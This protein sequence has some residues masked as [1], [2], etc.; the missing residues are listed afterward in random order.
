LQKFALLNPEILLLAVLAF[1]L[2]LGK[3]VGLRL[4]ELWRFR[5]LVNS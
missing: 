3:Y 2:I 5:K 4:L 1:N